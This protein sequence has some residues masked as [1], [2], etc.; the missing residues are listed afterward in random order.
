M[1]LNLAKL[2]KIKKCIILSIMQIIFKFKFKKTIKINIEWIYYMKKKC[3]KEY[4][5]IKI[6]IHK[7]L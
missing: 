4:Q 2:F 5:K 1:L 6:S 3:Q 7:K